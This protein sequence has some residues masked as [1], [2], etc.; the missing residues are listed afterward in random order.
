MRRSR[1]GTWC[2]GCAVARAREVAL[3]VLA[4]RGSLGCPQVLKRI[5]D[6]LDGKGGDSFEALSSEFYTLIPHTVGMQKMAKFI[7]CVCCADVLYRCTAVRV[8]PCV[9]MCVSWRAGVCAAHFSRDPEQL[10]A[11]LEMVEVRATCF[12]SP[13]PLRKHTHVLRR[14]A[15]DQVVLASRVLGNDDEGL[16]NPIDR[17]YKC[18]ARRRVRMRP[19]RHALTCLGV[20]RAVG[21]ST[22]RYALWPAAAASG[23]C[24][25]STSGTRMRR[26]TA[27]TRCGWRTR[28]SCTARRTTRASWGTWATCRCVARR[29]GARGGVGA[30]ARSPCA[31]SS[32]GT[33]A[34]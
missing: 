13:S 23:A 5:A 1:G 27:S 15:L 2:A 24:S 32:C 30:D 29:R 16:D 10:K 17:H 21:A 9:S 7:M 25:N 28:T 8:R 31:R 20:P 11:K 4:A 3:C 34:G 19:R 6:R 18:A 22:A 12:V 14:Q 26:R 33:A